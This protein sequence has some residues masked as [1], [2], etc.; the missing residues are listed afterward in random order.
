MDAPANHDQASQQLLGVLSLGTDL[1]MGHPMEHA[2]RQS[3]LAV[4]LGEYAG[5]DEQQ[6]GVVHYA[7][8]VAWV[9]CHV[10]AYEQATWFRDDR[11]FKA[12]RVAW[13]SAD[14]WSRRPMCWVGHRIRR[15][16]TDEPVIANRATSALIVADPG[17]RSRPPRSKCAR[18]RST[19]SDAGVSRSGRLVRSLRPARAFKHFARPL[20]R[21]PVAG[22]A[23]AEVV[24][25]HHLP[26]R[27]NAVSGE[28]G[29]STEQERRA[30][31]AFLVRQDF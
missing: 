26:D 28:V 2:I 8:L 10:D 23:V 27:G 30:G 6:R 15:T 24:V 4:R 31:R 25:G 3:L 9:G 1:G 18:M 13:T 21:N 16:Q 7:S 14:R 5:L 22:A 29:R 20:G 17:E 11:V 19:A 12:A